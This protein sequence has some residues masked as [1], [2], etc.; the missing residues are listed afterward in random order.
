MT[1]QTDIMKR[2]IGEK[3][4][5]CLQ[6]IGV[7]ISAITMAFLR[8][9][10]FT[11][12]LIVASPIFI[13]PMLSYMKTAKKEYM[14]KLAAYGQ[15]A[16]YAEQALN[17]IKVVEAFGMEETEVSNYQK[18][19]EVSR[20]VGIKS[21]FKQ[22]IFSTAFTCCFYWYYTYMF[23]MAAVFIKHQIHNPLYDRPYHPGDIMACFFGMIFGVM[24][25]AQ[26]APQIAEIG[27]GKS[28]GKL[29]FD[30]IE[31]QPK[32]DQDANKN[33][34]RKVKGRIEFKNVD[35]YYPSRPEQKVL[36]NFSAVF[37]EGKTTALVG[38]SG[39]GKSTIVQLI[40][41]FYDADQGQ[42]LIDGVDVKE[43]NLRDLR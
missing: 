17:A 33:N 39:S 18:Y 10:N 16:G 24:S 35:F 25:L 40:E 21:A 3:Y 5:D 13:V 43:Y 1:Q 15:S 20:K 22:A 27:R 36:D 30:I 28:S 14:I 9:W 2:A 26:L 37:E 11:L 31:R 32:I 12:V 4:A 23:A 19:L 7:V 38:P 29:A 34:K 42:V 6:A 41:R 8:G